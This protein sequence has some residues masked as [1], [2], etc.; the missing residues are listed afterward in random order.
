MLNL[1]AKERIKSRVSIQDRG[2]TSPC[3]IST[4]SGN[5]DGYTKLTFAGKTYATHRFAYEVFVGPI[6]A[7]LVIDH[8]CS[9]RA[10]CNPDHLEPVTMRENGMRGDTPQARNAAK[11][12][13]TEGHPLAPENLIPSNLKQGRR[14]CLTCHRARMQR[15]RGR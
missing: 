11:T 13:C 4:R 7:G 5:G 9:Q 2:H 14:A 3:W 1:S 12:H 6:P 8:L 15:M 10:C